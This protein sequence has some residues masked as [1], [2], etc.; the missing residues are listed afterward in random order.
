MRIIK[1]NAIDSTNTYLKRISDAEVLEDYT[2]VTAKYQT[3]GR[4]QMGTIWDSE[5][6]KNLTCS[7]FKDDSKIRVEHQFY[8]SMVTSLAIVKTLQGFNVPKLYVKWPND[9]LS[10]NKKVCG[11]LIENVIKNTMLECSIIGIGLNVNQTDF[12][13][14]PN[15]SSLKIL[16][17]RVFNLD[18][19]LQLIQ[20][21]LK[22]YFKF[23]ERGN[24]EFIKSAYENRLFR[25]DKPSSF[26]D[27][28]G[29]IFAGFIKGIN[30]LGNL[31][32]LLED[33]IVK[34]FDLKEVTLLY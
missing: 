2:A 1:L 4:G 22:Y 16:T 7:V 9:I 33:D 6:A 17:G 32:I 19:L 29:N 21:N 18:E 3:Q 15:A 5:R 24:L 28:Q 25:K 23:L 20:K 31:Q 26:K 14:L 10:E 13:Q 34:V 12:K 30:D 11:I 27:Q 8:I